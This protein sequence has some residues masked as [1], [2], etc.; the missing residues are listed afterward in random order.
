ML[1]DIGYG[2]TRGVVAGIV[3]DFLHDNA[4]ANPLSDRVPGKNS[5]R[6]S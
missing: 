4:S 3:R 5:G 6:D 2:L 1:V